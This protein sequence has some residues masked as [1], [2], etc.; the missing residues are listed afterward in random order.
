MNTW[1]WCH[2][3]AATCAVPLTSD[4]DD[5]IVVR[6]LAVCPRYNPSSFAFFVFS[7]KIFSIWIFPYPPYYQRLNGKASKSD[8]SY[9]WTLISRRLKS[10]KSS[11]FI[12]TASIYLWSIVKFQVRDASPTTRRRTLS[13]MGLTSQSLYWMVNKE[14]LWQLTGPARRLKNIHIVSTCVCVC[15]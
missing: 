12:H 6:L 2:A 11:R 5:V 1:R 7:I 9:Y 13:H 4:P 3:I 10:R 15:G 14:L 8:P